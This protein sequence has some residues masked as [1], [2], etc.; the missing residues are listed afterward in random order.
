[1]CI[2]DFYWADEWGEISSLGDGR[3]RRNLGCGNGDIIIIYGATCK[4]ILGGVQR[5]S[6]N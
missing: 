1:M 5:S 6:R 3:T 2:I 4:K